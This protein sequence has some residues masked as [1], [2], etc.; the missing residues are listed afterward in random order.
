M[1]RI[2]VLAVVAVILMVGCPFLAVTFAR[3]AG[4]AVCFLLF[5]FLDPLFSGVCGFVAGKN[6]KRDWAL[7]LLS[8]GLFL[9]GSWLF[10]DFGEPAVLLYAGWYFVIGLLAM[11]IRWLVRRLIEGRKNMKK[12]ISIICCA[13]AS[14]L[15]GFCANQ[16]M[17]PLGASL[18][19][20]GVALLAGS[21]VVLSKEEKKSE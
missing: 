20:I 3:G 17:T 15:I 8:P 16:L 18:F 19:A 7:M 14:G 10:F 13:L 9:I 5:F 11:L 21:I 2:L 1:K 6:V 4:M 12:P